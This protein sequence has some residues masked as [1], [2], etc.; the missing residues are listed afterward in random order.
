MRIAVSEGFTQEGLFAEVK[1][2][3]PRALVSRVQ[4]KVR[5][6]LRRVCLQK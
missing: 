3:L 1:P 4:I 5:A 6:S 2:S